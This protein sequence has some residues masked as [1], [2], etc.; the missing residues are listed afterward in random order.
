MSFVLRLTRCRCWPWLGVGLCVLG[1]IMAL[2]WW[3]AGFYHLAAPQPFRIGYEISPPYQYMKSDGTPAGLAIEIFKE[4][5]RR[6]NIPIEWVHCP[7]PGGPDIN[8]AN[9]N[10]DLWPLVGDLPERRD[11]FYI[12]KPWLENS[13][14][15]ITRED[16]QVFT[17]ADTV[18]R[19]LWHYNSRLALRE[20][21]ANFPG[22][23]PV[24]IPTNRDVL[25]GV[26]EGKVDAGMI[27]VS[28]AYSGDYRDLLAVHP[29]VHLRY[30][31]VPG[32]G[33]QFGVGASFKRPGAIKAAKAIREEI[34]RLALDGTASTIFLRLFTDPNNE[35]TSIFQL[36]AVEKR[37]FYLELGIAA[38]VAMLTLLGFQTYRFRRARN[39]ADAASRAKS[40]FLA[41]MSHEIRT[42]MNGVT[43]MIEL[44]LSNEAD[45]RQ[46][47]LLITASQSAET[48]M[49]VVNDILDFSKM[50]ASKLHLESVPLDLRGLAESCGK[51]L[52]LQAHQ[53]GLELIVDLDPA[54]PHFILGDP[55]RL[56]QVLGNLLGNAI[57]FTAQGGIVL[58]VA[59]LLEN[60][61]T[62]LHFSVVDSGIGIPAEKQ[63]LLFTAF[64][65]A[66][67]ST[68]RKFGGTGL[69]L[70]ICLRI[71][72]L[73]GGRI[74]LESTPGRGSTFQFT[75]PLHETVQP[76]ETG[77]I[78]PP[79]TA[80][81]LN[82]L[83]VDDHAGNRSVLERMLRQWHIRTNCVNDGAAVLR[84]VED[85]L[86][87]HTPYTAILLDHRMPGMDGFEVTAKLQALLGSASRLIIMLTTDDYH[88]TSARYRELG[89]SSHVVKPVRLAELQG[90]LCRALGGETV[91]PAVS[92]LAPTPSA[93]TKRSLRVL[94]AEDNAVN[95]K[96]ALTMLKQQGHTVILAEN[97]RVAVELW[98]QQ[99]VDLIL[100]DMHMPEMDGLAATAAI[101]SEELVI[102]K[103]TLI[104]AMTAAAMKEDEERCR[105]SGM[106]GYITK[107]IN[108][109]KVTAYL[110]SLQKLPTAPA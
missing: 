82:V 36:E 2:G 64:S 45:P 62:L 50:E 7:K 28:K 17:P 101:R 79:E 92:A 3:L 74:W 19:P 42:P 8:L 53:K 9:G 35:I 86:R 109:A 33:V 49:T 15:L 26:L 29:E 72:D 54:C 56:R 52:A 27:W 55:V 73:M 80:R 63:H 58:R 14:C 102:G 61:R 39:T 96:V 20:L 48:L 84:V 93:L 31:F 88:A 68:T 66:D 34:G 30:Y 95:Q 6:R 87:T 25:A 43:G 47:D 51:S 83:I 98:R 78:L 13:L 57:K 99:P 89:V 81:E 106:D 105:A 77:M 107:P 59:T 85:A 97:G 108:I 65:Q 18:G 90:V 40:E 37:G 71:I 10:V 11:L 110:E 69:G 103:H 67:S 94:L 100:M 46:R 76:P 60:S 12:T 24:P 70:A 22:A 23:I 91:D 44:A 5:C 41:N 21:K 104:V 4:A 16:T 32:G 1:G 38:L 75:I